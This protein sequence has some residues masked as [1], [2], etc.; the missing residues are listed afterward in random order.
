VISIR[1]GYFYVFAGYSRGGRRPEQFP[2]VAV[3]THASAQLFHA[4]NV[5]A[6]IGHLEFRLHLDGHRLDAVFQKCA[7]FGVYATLV[8]V[9]FLVAANQTKIKAKLLELFRQAGPRR[10]SGLFPDRRLS[11][12][13][14]KGGLGFRMGGLKLFYSDLHLFVCPDDLVYG[15]PYAIRRHLSSHFSSGSCG[16]LT[17]GLTGDITLS[18]NMPQAS[19]NKTG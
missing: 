8:I 17:L 11:V 12:G 13:I 3:Q 15:C 16:F 19:K 10:V 1:L 18:L 14:F 4:L 7:Y 5:I 9:Y 6:H 2:P